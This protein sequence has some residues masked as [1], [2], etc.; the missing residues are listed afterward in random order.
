MK[1]IL[2]ILLLTLA[3]KFAAAQTTTTY[4][5]DKLYRLT[6]ITYGNGSSITYLY[7]ANG[8]RTNQFVVGTVTTYTFIGN[9]NWSVAANWLGNNV[10][11]LNLPNGSVVIIDPVINGECVLD[12]NQTAMPGSIIRVMAGKKFRVPGNVSIQ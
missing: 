12:V 4:E 8:N 3:A 6:K 2:P 7:D 5:Y 10:P 9:G 11:P 1:K